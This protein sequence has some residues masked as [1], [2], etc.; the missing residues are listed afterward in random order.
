MQ[1]GT[2]SIPPD[3]E[4]APNPDVADGDCDVDIS[5]IEYN[6]SLTIAERILQH[7][8][9]LAMAN[10]FRRAGADKSHDSLFE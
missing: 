2:R 6:L 7:D 9:A 3:S 10:A 5:L 1:R 8:R 4:V